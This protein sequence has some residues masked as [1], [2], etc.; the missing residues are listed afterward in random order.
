[1]AYNKW[2]ISGAS[3]VY[4][5]IGDPID[6]SLSPAIQNT[7]FQVTRIDAVYVPFCVQKPYLKQAVDGLRALGV[8][9]FNV[10]APH[11]I[12]VIRH[13]D[14]L[15]PFAK[16]IGSVNTVLNRNG[17]L[18]GYNTDGPGALKT[19][20]E[21]EAPLKGRSLLLFGAGGAGRAIAHSFAS[22]V[23]TIRIVN[24]T[25]ARAKQLEHRLLEKYSIDIEIAG[26]SSKSIKDFVE[27]ADIIVNA[28]SMSPGSD[29]DSA[30]KQ[31]WFRPD[32]FVLDVV[33]RPV[34]TKLLELARTAG[35]TT[36]GGLNMLVHQ[37]ACSFELWTGRKAPIDAMRH[38]IQL[39][40]LA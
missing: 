8:K 14:K 23:G 40:S 20:E 38:A 21:A 13:L 3:N 16:E 2:T 15:E 18:C 6:H 25:L 29:S 10:T 34:E 30:L 4:G 26:L 39:E 1:L 9:G 11:K 27:E 17:S 24:R 35:A 5:I 12:D 19:L 28:S 22:R 36:I 37:G 7:A 32:Q 33:Y 31:D